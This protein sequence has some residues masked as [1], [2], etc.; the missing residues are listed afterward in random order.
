MT[1]TLAL[2]I[3]SALIGPALPPWCEVRAHIT[4]HIALHEGWYRAGSLPQRLNNP[5]AIKYAGQ[6]GA[7][8]S[9]HGFAHWDSPLEGWAELERLVARKRAAGADFRRAWAYLRRHYK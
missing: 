2:T 4:E 8:L 6:A 9:V 3:A 1:P 5:G 7:S